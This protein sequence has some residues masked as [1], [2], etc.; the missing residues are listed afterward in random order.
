MKKIIIMISFLV[1]SANSIFAWDIIVQNQN[2][3]DHKIIFAQSARCDLFFLNDDEVSQ[4]FL[5]KGTLKYGDIIQIYGCNATTFDA[6]V[7]FVIINNNYP[8]WNESLEFFSP[9]SGDAKIKLHSRWDKGVAY[10]S[11]WITQKD[12]I[13][14]NDLNSQVGIWD[15]AEEDRVKANGYKYRVQRGVFSGMQTSD[16]QVAGPSL[17]LSIAWSKDKC[18]KFVAIVIG[19]DNMDEVDKLL[20]KIY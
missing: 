3:T 11:V 6:F 2:K 14:N 17:P 7:N 12:I 9:V 15:F 20:S 1:V 19:N 16:W 5:E 18:S 4:G 13:N 10:E 8:L